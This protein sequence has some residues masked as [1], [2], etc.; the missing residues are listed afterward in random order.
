MSNH[1]YDDEIQTAV[2]LA[3]DA[4]DAALVYYGDA[5]VQIKE[6]GSPVTEADHAANGVIVAG[7]RDAFP[8]DAILSEE[9]TDDLAR[10][11]A[12]RVWIVDP[13]DGTRE[14]L[15]ENGEFSIMIGLVVDDE[16]VL[17]VVYRPDGDL[18]Y[19]AVAGQGAWVEDSG[20]TR[21]LQPAP[22][23]VDALRMTGSRS[24]SEPVI[25]RMRDALGVADVQPSGSVGLKC[26]LIAEGERDVYVHP[27]PYLKE[28]D[29]CAPEVI[30]RE[31][32]GTVTD[33]LGTRL[34]YNKENPRQPHGILAVA[35][36]VHE[37]VLEVIEPIYRNA[38]D[39]GDAG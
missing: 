11:D 30:L 39:A 19:R 24:H 20:G 4:A 9:S 35:P 32:G 5:T 38:G 15:A 13:L 23:D 6:G 28:W 25:D 37:H 10:L 29:T 8:D 34:R 17:G 22:A 18:L 21:A 7:I 27:V 3:R 36:G 12:R 16:P 33:C 1:A 14:F 2:R 26:A 31:A